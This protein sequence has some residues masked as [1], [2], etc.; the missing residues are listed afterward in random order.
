MNEPKT[1]Q[2]FL[3]LHRRQHR[4]QKLYTGLAVCWGL[5]A[6]ASIGVIALGQAAAFDLRLAWPV[7]GTAGA[8][9]A[10]LV[11]LKVLLVDW[12][13]L[14][15]IVQR[16]ERHHPDLN[17]LLETASEQIANNDP[18][19]LDY[20]QQRVLTE[21]LSA[22]Y[23]QGWEFEANGRLAQAHLFHAVAMVVFVLAAMQLPGSG[24]GPVARQDRVVV[25]PG[26]FEIERGMSRIISA[27]FTRKKEDVILVV[28]EPGQDPREM[29]MV[30]SLDDPTYSYR[31]ANVQAAAVYRVKYDDKNGENY[32]MTVFDYPALESS[33]AR[34]DY[35]EFTGRDDKV[36]P[37]TRRLTVVEGTGLT[38]NFQF[39]KP[40]KSAVLKARDGGGDDLSLQSVADGSQEYQLLSDFDQPGE[41]RY[42]LHLEDAEGRAN[43]SPARYVFTVLEN[44]APALKFEAPA[45]DTEVSSIEE[46]RLQGVARDDFGLVDAGIG[47][48][49]AGE[50][51]QYISLGSDGL[52]TNKLAVAHVIRMEDLGV[53]VGQVVSYFLWADDHVQDGE[54]RRG[55][56]DLLF[57]TVRPFEEIFRQNR[58][59]TE[60]MRQQQQQQGE[61]GE[62]GGEQQQ[63]IANMLDTQKDIISATWNLKRRDMTDE[64]IGEDI[65]VVLDSQEE[66]IGLLEQASALL[67]D[68][69][70]GG[71]AY[72]ANEAMQ[73]AADRLA[74]AKDAS[75]DALGQALS[76]AIVEEQTALQH[77]QK[78][79]ENE[80]RVSRQ[81]A[82]QQR[83]QQQG[84][85]NSN[86][87]QRQL[88]QLEMQD[89]RNNYELESKAERQQQQA[90][91]QGERAEQ[92]QTL[93]RLKELARRQSDLNERVQELQ[94]A[95][96]DA[97][98]EAEQERIERELKRLQ[99]EQRELID[100]LDEVQQR[101]DRNQNDELAESR[102][103]LEE[104]RE[105]MEETARNLQ[106]T[107]RN[108]LSREELS[109]AANS[110]SRASQNLEDVREDY[111]EQTASEFADAMREMRQDARELDST[112]EEL[113]RAIDEDRKETFR[114]LSDEGELKQ[115]LDM[116]ESQKEQLEDLL[117]QMEQVSREAEESEKLLSQELEDG[118]RR[119]RQESI[120]VNDDISDENLSIE[121]AFDELANRMRNNLSNRTG[122]I[123]RELTENISELRGT[124]ED[125]AEKIIGSDEDAMRFAADQLDALREEVER[126]MEQAMNDREGQRRGNES[127]RNQEGDEQ[128]SRGEGQRSQEAEPREGGG[129]QEDDA[130]QENQR[131]GRGQARE[132][133]QAQPGQGQGRS[134]NPQEPQ[135]AQGRGGQPRDPNELPERRPDG[136]PDNGGS[137]GGSDR[138]RDLGNFDFDGP[139]TGLDYRDWEDRLREVEEV[140]EI[141][142]L[143]NQVSE[144]RQ[145]ARDIRRDNKENGKPPKWDLVDMQ[146]LRPMTEINKRLEEEL[147]LRQ[148]KREMVP[149]DHEPVPAQY[150]EL[151]RRY[152]ERI[153]GRSEKSDD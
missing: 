99:E 147:S 39:N 3:M 66:L 48:Q 123:Q 43:R 145:S 61:G 87:A 16:I 124:V 5:C 58:S 67:Q 122:D 152:Y 56:S 62:Q 8:V 59:A 150:S 75:G 109:Q 142:E 144:V 31:L 86:R 33:K 64:K 1:L 42:E 65:Q 129:R 101:M 78:L 74:K 120:R 112:Q 115:A 128:N 116:A 118:V 146:I 70:S 131:Q 96:L 140:I 94:I 34:L 126:E 63:S 38:F 30:Q 26:D 92:L 134:N 22:A 20:L 121:E 93:N 21:A 14:A 127:E 132:E 113:N 54:V 60:G 55:F 138:F 49:L 84:R 133:Q 9:L 149:V 29:R 107:A 80:F 98:D 41:F 137:S 130:Q 25:E 119:A 73:A 10:A 24:G 111:R 4:R 69:E 71:Q 104:A 105:Q 72:Q 45:G 77:L 44:A 83:Q 47:Y 114:S 32:R 35:P 51:P 53:E 136:N 148:P 143:R 125:A 57:A 95:L 27:K 97:E 46:M 2:E 15:E 6:L 102:R 76:G 52:V 100:D 135:T 68:A 28:M 90:R 50:E 88:D 81:Q 108:E 91:Q 37:N 23:K 89:S 151:V 117:Q 17:K 153:G 40:L 85:G 79:R 18:D 36:I 139:L 13:S 12:L 106:E 110:G 7:I 11:F 19:K 103:Q 141:P 82:R